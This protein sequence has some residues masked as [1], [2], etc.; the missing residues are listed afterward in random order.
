MLGTGKRGEHGAQNTQ[1][2]SS[3]CPPLPQCFNQ[4][5]KDLGLPSKPAPAF[6]HSVCANSPSS[7]PHC[8]SGRSTEQAT[9]I[10]RAARCWNS[11]KGL[12][13]ATP[14]LPFL[15]PPSLSLLP[16]GDTACLRTCRTAPVASVSIKSCLLNHRE[17]FPFAGWLDEHAPQIAATLA[18]GVSKVLPFPLPP[19]F[20]L[21][22]SSCAFSPPALPARRPFLTRRGVALGRRRPQH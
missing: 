14:L 5:F 19:R 12:P 1:S 21:F 18:P 6:V 20:F 11:I 3:Q 15:V 13:P 7:L 4:V 9:V 17:C 22:F 2:S 10:R 16:S 8:R